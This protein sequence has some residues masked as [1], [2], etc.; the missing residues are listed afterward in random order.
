MQDHLPWWKGRFSKKWGSQDWYKSAEGLIGTG[1][2]GQG[3]I[4][5]EE[6][7]EDDFIGD[8]GIIGPSEVE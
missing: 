5:K 7:E 8:T 2:E 4:C 1:V 3:G 6:E